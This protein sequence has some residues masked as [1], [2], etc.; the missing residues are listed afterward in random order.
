[1]TALTHWDPFRALRRE[2]NYEG[3]LR[4]VFG[5]AE[6]EPAEPPVEVSESDTHLTVK[7]VVAGVGKDQLDIS[8]TDNTFRVRGETRKESEEKKTN[9]YR[10]EIRYGAFERA[11]RLPA[12]VDA[13]K[14]AADL[15]N[16]IL[17]V[18]LPKSKTPKAQQI[19]IAA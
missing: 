15:K 4:E 8:V 10:Q 17:K 2:E 16:G 5:R 19:K 12:G 1:M 9:Y 11:V 7:M 6:S 18:T 14:A 13:A 3:F